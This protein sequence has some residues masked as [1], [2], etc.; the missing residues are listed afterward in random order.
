LI[1]I[2]NV[3]VTETAAEYDEFPAWVA[4]I[5]QI[6]SATGSISMVPVGTTHTP[7]VSD[8]SV[9]GSPEDAVAPELKVGA[10]GVFEPGF[11]NVMDWD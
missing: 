8:T 6:P 5:V 7:G 1:E 10:V 4:T 9:T 2:G 11:V 3:C